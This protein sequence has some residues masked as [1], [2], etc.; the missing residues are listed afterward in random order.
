MNR[1]LSMLQRPF[2]RRSLAAVSALLVFTAC[3]PQSSTAAGSG[4]VIGAAGAA[5]GAPRGDAANPQAAAPVVQGRMMLPDFASLVQQHGPAVVN[6]STKGKRVSLGGRGMSPND[7]MFEF[8]RRFGIPG[9]PGIPG[10]PDPRGG[11]QSPQD[12]EGPSFRQPGGEG[13]G[14]IVSGDGLVLTNAHV[15]KDADEITVKLTDRRE[16]KAKLI[17]LDEATDVAVLRIDAKGLPTVRLGDPK[18]L[19]PGEWVFA[20]G[21]PFGFENSVTAGIVSS[22]GRGL[23]GQESRFVNFIQTDVAVNPGNSGGPLFNLDGEVVG[24]NSQIYSRSGGYMGI[25]FAIPIDLAGDIQ[26]QLVANGRVARGRIGVAIGEVN[27]DI[28]DSFG[29]DRPRGALVNSVEPGGPAA[30][31]GLQSGDI[32]LSANGRLIER[33]EELPTVIGL[34]RP[35]TDATLEVWRDRSVKRLPVRV[36]EL[37][38]PSTAVADAGPSATPPSAADRLG[39]VVRELTAE[40]RARGAAGDAAAGGTL[41]VERAQ[42]AASDSGIRRGDL[43]LGVNGK[44]TRSLKEFRDAVSQAGK[45]VALLVQR[46]DQ[47]VFIPVRPG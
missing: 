45:V 44:R 28:A 7:P 12:D 2:V 4:G 16:F 24:I 34:I 5:Q 1:V 21:S 8:F 11:P 17:G 33:S 22:T 41:V 43:I 9:M 13:S 14:F 30:K 38:P 40:E 25:S 18:K 26:R 29:L 47:Q 31:A 3:Q 42:G 27:A 20:I 36:G 35:G 23:G 37:D 15:V 10:G 32:I 46:G 6:I 19:R 39:L